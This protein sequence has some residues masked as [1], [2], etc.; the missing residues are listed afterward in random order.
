M[1]SNIDE[2]EKC[3]ISRVKKKFLFQQEKM[4]FLATLVALAL[5]PYIQAA[6]PT[7]GKRQH[8]TSEVTLLWIIYK[9]LW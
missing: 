4:K 1:A 7:T 3:I 8:K 2:S 6:L 9:L 5:L